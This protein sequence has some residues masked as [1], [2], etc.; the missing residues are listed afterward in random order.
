MYTS[1]KSRVKYNNEVS[2]SFEC[3][4]GV[5]Q[6]ECLSPFLFSMFIN[7]IEDMYVKNGFD[8]IEVNMFK[9]FLILYADDIVIFA[10]NPRDLQSSLDMLCVYCNKW[11]LKVNTAK[12]KVMIFKKGGRLQENLNF[13]FNDS[14]VEIVNKFSYLG[15]VLTTGGSFMEA[16]DTLAGQALKA[17]YKM[18]KYLYKF[19]DIS[20]KHK[21]ELFDKL[22]L[23]ILNYGS[24]IWG[25]NQ[26]KSVERI[27]MHFCKRILGVKKNTQN[28]FIYG[29]LGRM[30][31]QNMRY[32]NIIKFWIK[33]LLSDENKYSRKIYLLLKQD[34]T[35]NPSRKNW[36]SFLRDLLC[37]LGFHEVWLFQTIGDPKLFLINVKQRLKDQFLQNWSGRLN[38]SSRAIFY[39]YIS[40][41][42]FQP[43][44]NYLSVRK[45]RVC[46]S[47]LRVC[48]HRLFIETGRWTRPVSTPISERKC[49]FCDKLE[50]EYHFVLECTLYSDLRKLFIPNYYVNR[51]NMQKFI[52]LMNSENRRIMKNLSMYI[53]KAFALRASEL[54]I[55]NNML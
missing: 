17:I 37:I 19:T 18:D 5:R 47:R 8:G 6:G 40:N 24:E 22:I 35:D 52:E 45:F 32:Y 55:N 39:R 31:L 3:T 14:I 53:E 34:I 2:N 50:D 30:P 28:D 42:R 36:C 4:L 23:P 12:T 15:I 54:Y 38:D 10:N 49:I 25:F 43:Y 48:S 1:V 26:G 27:H 7:D 29:E 51:P 11:K 44:L 13:Y 41:H 9:M 46:M 33:L 21:V 20:V 16:Q